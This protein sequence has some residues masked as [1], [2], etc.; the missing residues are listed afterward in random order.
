MSELHDETAIGHAIRDQYFLLSLVG[1]AE[2]VK[3]GLRLQ[4]NAE[5]KLAVVLTTLENGFMLSLFHDR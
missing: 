4:L 3:L 2:P 5:T 1:T